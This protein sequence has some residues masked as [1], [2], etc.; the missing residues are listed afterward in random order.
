MISTD[1]LG[2][3]SVTPDQLQ[4]MHRGDYILHARDGKLTE[5]PCKKIKLPLNPMSH[6]HQQLGLNAAPDGT[7]YATIRTH[8]PSKPAACRCA[9]GSPAAEITPLP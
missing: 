6:N 3:V 8:H 9:A 5:V 4:A 2:G 1:A 7:L